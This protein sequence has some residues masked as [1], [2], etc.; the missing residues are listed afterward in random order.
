[1][2]P[3][4][5]QLD[6][7][8]LM[9]P[10]QNM[11]KSMAGFLEKPAILFT[12]FFNLGITTLSNIATKLSF[13]CGAADRGLWSVSAAQRSYP[14]SSAPPPPPTA[15]PVAATVMAVTM[16][17]T[18]TAAGAATTTTAVGASPTATA[19]AAATA[20]ALD[21]NNN[22]LKAA[23]EDSAAAAAATRGQRRR[24][25]P[26]ARWRGRGFWRRRGGGSAGMDVSGVSDGGWWSPENHKSHLAISPHC[27]APCF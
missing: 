26:T 8:W 18:V 25:R 13:R 20:T 2:A 14:M 16:T 1:M 7:S 15:L 4:R 17:A 11:V 9:E 27:E 22:Q 23:A 10:R 19:A 24:R 21:T 3:C 12:M 5:C 6:C